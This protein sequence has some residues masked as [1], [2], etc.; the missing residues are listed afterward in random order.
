VPR[1]C[2]PASNDAVRPILLIGVVLDVGVEE[3]QGAS[4]SILLTTVITSVLADETLLSHV[5][6]D[7]ELDFLKTLKYIKE[8]QRQ[9]Q[10][11]SKK[12]FLRLKLIY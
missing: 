6:E 9:R 11:L 2:Q 4:F 3:A 7:V 12:Y 1:F 5:L 8:R 10:I